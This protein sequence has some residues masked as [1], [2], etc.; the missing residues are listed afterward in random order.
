MRAALENEMNSSSLIHHSEHAVET[1]EP[2]C[3]PLWWLDPEDS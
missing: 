1:L 3:R 2:I